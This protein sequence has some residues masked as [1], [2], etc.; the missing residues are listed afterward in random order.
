VKSLIILSQVELPG[1]DCE[2]EIVGEEKAEQSPKV[3]IL[4][5][6]A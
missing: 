4:I 6:P 3:Q 5:D 2:T 1:V